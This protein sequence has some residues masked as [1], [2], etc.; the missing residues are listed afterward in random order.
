MSRPLPCFTPPPALEDRLRRAEQRRR[1]ALDELSRKLD[2]QPG[3][4]A[5]E[6]DAKPAPEAKP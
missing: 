3:E 5:F 4:A 6:E 1:R 2:S